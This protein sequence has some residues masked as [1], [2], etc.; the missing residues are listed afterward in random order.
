VAAVA[1]RDGLQLMAAAA[2]AAWARRLSAVVAVQ[3]RRDTAAAVLL[4][5]V[6]AHPGVAAVLPRVA[7]RRDLAAV[8]GVLQLV[9]AEP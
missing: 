8:R 6:L 9:A 4:H 1:V 2:S 7:R 5:L 3:G